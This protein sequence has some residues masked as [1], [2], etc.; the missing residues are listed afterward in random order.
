MTDQL[1]LLP[2]PRQLSLTGGA[3]SLPAERLIALNAA[4]PSALLFTAERVQAALR[5]SAGVEWPIVAGDAAPAARVCLRL[6]VVPG[7]VAHP[8]GYQLTITAAAIDIVA[9]T[10]AGVWYGALTLI[11]LIEQRRRELPQLRAADWPDFPNRGVMLDISRDRV[12][13]LDTLFELIDMLA[14]WKINQLQ[15]Y[16]EH[17]FAYQQHPDVWADA[18]PLTGAEVLA[19]DA[20]CRE[21]CIELVPNQNTFGHMRRWLIHPRYRPLAECPHGCDTGLPDWGHFNEPF[22]LAPENPGSLE[23]VRSLMDELL[24]HFASRQFNVGCD[25]AVELGQGASAASVAQRGKGRV[26]LE[27][28][29]KIYRE[30]KARGRTMQFWGDIIMEYPEL[31][32]E[33][34]R[35][36]VAMEW[37]YEADHPFADHGAKFA[38]SG[39]PFYVC[40]GTSSW[41][42]VAGRTDNA[43]QNLRNAA[44]NGLGHGAV[45]YLITDWGD[46]GHW[47][48]LPVSYLPL[49]YG[50]GLA[51]AVAAN[52]PLNPA[53]LASRFAFR[54]ET[55]ALGRVAFEL[56]NVYRAAGAPH[57]NSVLFRLLQESPAQIAGRNLNPATLTSILSQIDAAAA[58]LPQAQPACPDAELLRREF[59]WAAGLLRHACRRGLWVIRADDSQRAALAAEADALLAEYRYLWHARSR[60]GGFADSA[61]RLEKMRADYV[62]ERLNGDM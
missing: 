34:P 40:A 51:W 46:N 52:E 16:T 43:L 53:E 32:P 17:T 48:P 58:G 3:F 15:L 4:E 6:N 61:A 42:S 9:A 59:Q 5:Q 35:D 11:Q 10:P 13:T 57:N 30:V 7:A 18:S 33:L 28:L 8:Q 50:A 22:S 54:D 29:L 24:P 41:N 23:L 47:Q 1:L 31:V 25:E 27:F 56:G 45:G 49:A 60:P 19:L 62:G 39:V 20:Y 55:G 12:P 21:R 44:R 26:Y 14:G 2:A 36:A 38:A 37:G